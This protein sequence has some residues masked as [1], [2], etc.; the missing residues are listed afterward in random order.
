[1]VGPNTLMYGPIVKWDQIQCRNPLNT[2]YLQEKNK[3]QHVGIPSDGPC[4]EV[5]P[6]Q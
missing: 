2:H 4:I 6:I 3:L 5:G 1:M